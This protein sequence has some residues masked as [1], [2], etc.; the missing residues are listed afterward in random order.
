[1][2][3]FLFFLLGLF[4]TV[5][6][7]SAATLIAKSDLRRSETPVTGGTEQM[8]ADETDPRRDA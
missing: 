1:M 7:V 6:A 5:I 4:V 8:P 3:D 2:P